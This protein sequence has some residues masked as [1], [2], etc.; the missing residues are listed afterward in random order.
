MR[1]SSNGAVAP[2]TALSHPNGASHPER[3][4]RTP[5]GAV[6][7]RTALSHAERRCRTCWA[8]CGGSAGCGVPR[9]GCDAAPRG[10]H[11]TSNGAVAPRTALS[12]L[13]R[14]CR[15][16]NGAVAPRTALSHLERRCRTSNGAVA[17]VGRGA[18]VRLGA[19]AAGRGRSGWRGSTSRRHRSCATL[20]GCRR[21]TTSRSSAAGSSPRPSP[22]L[23]TVRPDGSPR[24]VPI[25]FALLGELLCFAVDEVKP[26]RDA[27]LARLGDIARDPRV[28]LLV[29][30]YDADWRA[31]WWVRIDGTRGRAR[32]RD[33]ARTGARR[34]RRPSTRPTGPRARP[35]RS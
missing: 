30:H 5:G 6:A 2:R 28:T 31:L 22:R 19:G 24:L 21:S 34:A 11:R 4:C 10:A 16:S 20:L 32:R 12:H 13:E 9:G 14:R 25:T 33:A 8:G 15:T 18:A 7:G 17:P 35:D 1:R 29:D 26:K 27:R 23:A 3:R